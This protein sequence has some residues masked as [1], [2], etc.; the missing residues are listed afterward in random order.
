[1]QK[2]LYLALMQAAVFWFLPELPLNIFFSLV[3]KGLI[4]VVVWIIGLF[5]TGEFKRLKLEI[6]R[7][8]GTAPDNN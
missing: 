7:A 6:E 4:F 1:M 5:L 2:P 3:V 8:R